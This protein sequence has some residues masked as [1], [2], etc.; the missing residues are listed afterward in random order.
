MIQEQLPLWSAYLVRVSG[1]NNRAEIASAAHIS[2]SAASRWLTGKTKPTNAA[3]VASFAKHYGRS[4]LE[5][6]VAA[7]LIDLDVA[8][9]GLT[10]DELALL[11][12]LGG[13]STE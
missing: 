7:R 6:F 8:V 12:D 10:D 4:P 5:A 3:H 9:A 1:T 13:Q 2:S 11:A